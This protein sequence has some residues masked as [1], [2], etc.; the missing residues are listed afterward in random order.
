MSGLLEH[1]IEKGEVEPPGKKGEKGK[2]R[3]GKAKRGGKSNQRNFTP[4]VVRLLKEG[5]HVS[6]RATCSD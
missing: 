1:A 6:A 3:M 2:A 4:T 5:P